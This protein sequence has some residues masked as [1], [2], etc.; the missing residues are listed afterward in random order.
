LPRRFFPNRTKGVV[1][2][3]CTAIKKEHLSKQP[4][5]YGFGIM[6]IDNSEILVS[7]IRQLR[8]L[9]S[10]VAILLTIMTF[11]M[12]YVLLHLTGLVLVPP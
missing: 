11:L 1:L 4:M 8:T 5:C 12:V 9:L 6:A 10:F 2:R 7:E 3:V